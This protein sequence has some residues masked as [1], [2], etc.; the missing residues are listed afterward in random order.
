MWLLHTGAAARADVVAMVLQLS[1]SWLITEVAVHY[2]GHACHT[3]TWYT[4]MIATGSL[5]EED[6]NSKLS[7]AT[8]K[9]VFL[10]DNWYKWCISST[11]IVMFARQQT[12]TLIFPK[13]KYILNKRAC[14][15]MVIAKTWMTM[16]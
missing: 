2:F 8:H 14:G 13:H 5:L 10:I 4:Q 7:I 6:T 15:N 12:C 11:Q 16:H 3:Y 1:T 9:H